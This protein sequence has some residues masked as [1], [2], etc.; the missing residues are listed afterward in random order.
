[1]KAIQVIK[2]NEIK[3][4][5]VDT[6]QIKSDNEVLVKIRAFGICGSDVAILKGKNPFVIY[7]RIIG[8]EVAGEVVQIGKDV[9]NLKIGDKVV[10]EPI[11]YC[12][13]CYACTHNMHNVCEELE[14]YGVHRDGGF[15]E[16]MVTDSK[17]WHKVD[18]SLTF[19]EAVVA[20][21]YTIGEQSTSRA[22]V[23]EGDF[24]LITGAGPA[25]LLACDVANMKKAICIVSEVNEKRLE[26]A[27]KFGAK[28]TINPQN[29][30]LGKRIME[31][32]NGQG[33]NVFLDTTGV[34]A[35]I[36]DAMNYMSVASRFVP[37]AFGDQQI[38]IDYK[39]LNK[40][41]IR[42]SG[43]RLQYEKF[44]VVVSYLHKKK[45]L[46]KEFVTHT[47]DA[48]DYEK[49]FSLFSEAGTEA[50]KVVLTFD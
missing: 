22:D 29:E 16:Y 20:E 37:F 46:L 15:C 31:I 30:D 5:E 19:A 40:K 25:G 18:N 44:P 47:F 3:M 9:M 49:A 23:K 6:P 17:K 36:H 12:G 27:K 42:I 14:V 39:T 50:I 41:E 2:A 43:T 34:H 48:K 45:E 4:I 13:K 8:H 35:V 38:P 33:V 32:T 21:P 24:V 10:L 1:M 26:T 7:P 11:E 28:F